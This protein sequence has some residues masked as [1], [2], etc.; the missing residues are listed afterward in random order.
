MN[1]AANLRTGFGISVSAQ[2]CNSLNVVSSIKNQDLK[3]SAII[4]Y[5]T[6]IILLSDIR[7][8][9]RFSAVFDKLGLYYHVHHNST[10]N[11]R[12][13]A[14]L[15]SK[16]V[17]H[18]VIDSAVDP[19]ENVLLLKIRIKNRELIIGSVYGPNDNH[20]LPFFNFIS[21]TLNRWNNIPC[22]LG[23]DWNATYSSL[24]PIE[25]PDV[26]FMRNIPSRIR[27]DHVR[28]LCDFADLSDPFRTLHPE[29]RDFS[30]QPSG[31]VRKNRSRID[32]FLVSSSLYNE[33]ESCTVAQGFCRKSF[34]HKPIFLSLK[35]MGKKCRTVIHDSTLSNNLAA[36]TVRLAVFKCTVSA[37]LTNAG[38]ISTDILNNELRKLNLIEGIINRI[39]YLRG[40]EVSS[41]LVLDETMEMHNLEASLSEDW[42]SMVPLAQLRD[43]ERQVDGDLFFEEILSAARDSLLTLQSRIREAES[44]KKRG[45]S[46]ELARLKSENYALHFDRISVLET[47]LN[48]ASEK[49]VSDRL[50]NYIKTDI[51]NSEKMTPRFLKLAEAKNDSNLNI[52]NNDNGLPFDTDSA[53]EEYIT[54]FY[55]S[56]YQVPNGTRVDFSNCVSDFLGDLTNHP[57]VRGC[58]LTAEDRERLEAGLRIEELDEAVLHCNMRSAPGIDGISNKFIKTFWHLFREPLHDY[59]TTCARKGQ[60]TGTFRTAMIRLIPKKGDTTQLK[61]WRPISLLSCFYKIISKAID[62]RLETVINKVTSLAQK[63]YNKNRYI[64]EALINTIDTIRH[65]E[66]SGVLGAILSIDQK[67]AFDSVFHGYMREVYSFFGFGPIFIQLLETIGTNRTAKII[68]ENGV[69]SRE[70]LLKRG[71]AQGNSPSPKK[72][73][74]GEQIL[75]FRLEF[76]PEVIGVYNSF[77][78]PRTVVEGEVLYP[79]VVKAAGLGLNVED[80]L[81]HSARKTSAF[82]DDTNGGFLRTAENL[83]RVKNILLDFGLMSGLETNVDKTTLMPIGQLDVPVPAEILDLGFKVVDKI[84]CLGLEI[85]NTASDLSSHFDHT[86]GK[87]RQLIGLWS[88]FNL[89]LVGRIAISKTM[90]ISQIGYIGCIITPT[91]D[92]IS[93]LQGAINKFVT[94]GIVIAENRLYLKPK[95]GGLGLINLTTYIAALQCSWLKRCS[96]LINDNWRWYLA[97]ACNFNLDML[98]EDDVDGRLHPVCAYIAKSFCIL[99]KEYWALHEN[100]L[101]APL[102]DNSFFL[103]AAPERRAPVRGCV[104]KNLLGLRFYDDNKEALRNLRINCLV[105]A[106]RVVSFDLLNRTTGI[107]FP[108]AAYMNLTRA[109]N[110]AVK[111]YGGKVGSNGSSLPL[112]WLLLRVKKGSAR[113]RNIMESCSKRNHD[114]G[115]LRVVKTFFELIDR[116]VPVALKLQT[117]HVSWNLN[118][119]SNRLRTFCFQFFNNSLS[120]GAR[121]GA[122]YAGG[123]IIIDQRCTFCVKAG[124]LIPARETF[125]HLFYDCPSVSPLRNQFNNRYMYPANNNV[126]EKLFAFTG[127]SNNVHTADSFFLV[128]T[129]LFFNYTLWQAKLKKTVPSIATVCQEIDNHF[130]NV[131]NVSAKLKNLAIDSGT[132]LCRRWRE[133]RG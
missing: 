13:V 60:L 100:F 18:E 110:F 35:K 38:M 22:I 128:L 33:I 66:H 37:A 112:N 46:I 126:D 69:L 51:L 123:G 105:R 97:N 21:G 86:L 24:P 79:L 109:G 2:N 84:K 47:Y 75:L 19:Q 127:L 82:A 56:L 115:K 44:E 8:N 31:E 26:L 55:A 53:R 119:L 120:V 108:L 41:E 11:S 7:L 10:R 92:Q 78:V 28:D 62:A 20:C 87:I 94:S 107:N 59:I 67:K 27:S 1:A 102:V 98:R 111:K 125:P 68:F 34:D 118:F 64:Q 12:G 45:W 52:L 71:F 57:V 114:I 80:E 130:D 99:Q 129:C 95:D 116:P 30:Y 4:G 3:M 121:L 89:S 83:E 23:G 15:I 124:S 73:N 40:K 32:F 117:L 48:A 17:V 122:R 16:Q 58:K 74:I 61:N 39:V 42:D 14:V 104:D 113:F 36:D 65:C 93:L 5:R 133:R 131:A 25:N 91:N 29:A 101:L 90:L 77:L 96:T 85:N 132:P 81:L 88:R 103:R 9:H 6:D 50:A 49:F 76:D 106:G 70:I 63:A 43:F 72:Y 54:D